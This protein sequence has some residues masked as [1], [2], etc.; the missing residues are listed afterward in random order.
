[1]IKK[2]VLGIIV[3]LLTLSFLF[4]GCSETTTPTTTSKAT[5]SASSS[6]TA[7]TTSAAATST[8]AA[9]PANWWDEFG[10]PVY[11]GTLNLYNKSFSTTFDP[12]Q[13]FMSNN[14]LYEDLFNWDW[15]VDRN[16]WSFSTTFVPAQYY[17]GWL[18][19]S[20]EMTDPQTLVINLRQGVHWHDKAPTNG[21]EFTSAD[22]VEH[23][24]RL[25][26]SGSGYSVPTP[27]QSPTTFARWKSITAPDDYTVVINFS[28][29]SK[30]LNLWSI[31]EVSTA[32][33]EAPELARIDGLKDW[34]TV[35]GTGPWMISDLVQ[36]S[37]ITY[38]KNPNYWGYDE[39]H[40]ENKIP[41]VDQLKTYYIPELTTAIAALKSGQLDYMDGLDWQQ[42]ETLSKSN[43]D[44]IQGNIPQ[45]AWAID[46]RCDTAPF[47]DIRVRKALQMAIDLPTIA[48]HY[49]GGTSAAEPCGIVNP[50]MTG[51]C[52][53]YEDWD[54]SL[55]DEYAYNPEGAKALLAEAGFPNGFETN[56]LTAGAG[57]PVYDHEILELVKSYF[58]EIGVDMEIV[59]MDYQTQQAYIKSFKHDAMVQTFFCGVMY[60][61]ER[62]LSLGYSKG[63]INYTKNNDAYYDSLVEKFN[64]VKTE[65][66]AR[67]I[68]QSADLYALEQHWRI[69]LPR[70]IRINPFQPY[71]KGYSNEFELSIFMTPRV[72]IDS[73]IKASMGR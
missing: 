25:S 21:R 69:A 46:F 43:P 15:T 49:Y 12:Y 8:K 67:E 61:P 68:L 48:E 2:A 20:W 23:L 50:V 37:T 70:R 44:V 10:E 41:Y 16:E 3:C 33:I 5:T 63:S 35:V 73:E 34:K 56:C 47:D 14:Y 45:N 6:T 19:E 40:P 53:A 24:H 65:S 13:A 22:V 29:P 28:D 52:V 57:G 66:E 26:G 9:A 17:Q 27:F 38:S 72:W 11:G 64:S 42:G 39:R 31:L 59:V 1:M 58:S 60:P 71:L 62:A 18:A 51:W 55:K 7:K 36:N 4:S 54:Q 32:G 30:I